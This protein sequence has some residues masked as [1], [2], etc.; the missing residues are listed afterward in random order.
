MP[1]QSEATFRILSIAFNCFAKYNVVNTATWQSQ[2]VVG[3]VS[4]LVA[5]HN[6]LRNEPR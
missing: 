2:V 3:P 5:T 6:M 4:E 1:D